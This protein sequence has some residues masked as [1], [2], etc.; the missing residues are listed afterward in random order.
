MA[1]PTF[2]LPRP[3]APAER[4]NGRRRRC[5]EPSAQGAR[6]RLRA[7]PRQRGGNHP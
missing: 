2:P 6:R 7:F 3:A 5:G 1:L 4:P